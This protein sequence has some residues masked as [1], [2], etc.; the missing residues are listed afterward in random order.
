MER[1]SAFDIRNQPA[2]SVAEAAHYLRIAPATLQSWALGRAYETASGQ[3]QWPALF[4]VS[5]PVR[6]RLSFVN[7]VE[8]SILAAVRRD[9][10]VAMPKIRDAL[11]Y[12]KTELGV[13][14]PLC[15]QQFETDG[16]DLF[17]DHFG[18]LINASRSGQITMKEALRIALRRITRDTQGIPIVL[19]AADASERD[20]SAFVAFDPSIA[21]GRP[22]LVGSG[23]TVAAINDRFRGG[24]SVDLLAQDYGVERAAIEEAIRQAEILRAA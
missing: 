17:V 23:A 14:R 20:R 2:Y 21:F 3:K 9:H 10:G 6:R 15:D 5:D 1:P 7:L 18:Q 11:D 16:V 22:A 24:D 8:A 4:V 19:Y 13:D 12:V